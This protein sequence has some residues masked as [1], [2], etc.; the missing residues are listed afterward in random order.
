MWT[1]RIFALI[2]WMQPH[3]I[4]FNALFL[5]V[6]IK[7]PNSTNSS[8][9]KWLV[10]W[11]LCKVIKHLFFHLNQSWLSFCWAKENKFND[12]LCDHRIEINEFYVLKINRNQ[13]NR[14]NSI[15]FI[16]ICAIAQSAHV[17]LSF[18]FSNSHKIDL[19][20]HDIM[21]MLWK[22]SIYKSIGI[23]ISIICLPARHIS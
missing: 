19:K 18:A 10:L 1:T 13:T 3:C 14:F 23:H 21:L 8:P 12:H 7:K 17:C 15:N 6:I 5:S 11:W 22:K 20:V 9:R 16:L 2:L 4:N